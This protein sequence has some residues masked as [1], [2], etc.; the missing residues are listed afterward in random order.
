MR[1]NGR[2]IQVSVFGQ[3]HAEAVGAV[4]EGLPAGFRVDREALQAFLNRRAPGQ[5]KHTTA[6]KEADRPEFLSGL[7]EDVTCGGP[8]CLIIRNT[9][10]RSGDYEALQDI[11]RP[12]H[13]DWPARVKYGGA[14]DGRGGGMFSA[15]LTAP[16]CAAGALALQWLRE[17]GVEVFAHIASVGSVRDEAFDPVRVSAGVKERIAAH[18]LPVL[19]DGAEAEML[20]EIESARKEADSVGGTVEC[21]ATGLPVGLGG[22]LFEGLESDLAAA[23]FAIPA[24]KGVEFGSGFAAARMRGSEHNDPYT[25]ENGKVRPATNH[26]GGI[27]GGM[28][29]GM[30]LL[31]RAAFK[32]TPSIGKEQQSVS[33]GR[34]ETVRFT[35]KGRHDPCVVPRAV[36]V[37]EAVTALVLMDRIMENG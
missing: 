30:P 27:A 3:S 37:V 15:R 31:L 9:D 33:L 34:M 22:P 1:F 36:P 35:V 16:L 10:T 4:A 32:P 23:V 17:R 11:P 26:A 19:R 7:L 12:S 24:V 29:T 18:A 5:G 28:A 2:C 6:R 20:A 13:A 21:C 14:H 8:V 25:V